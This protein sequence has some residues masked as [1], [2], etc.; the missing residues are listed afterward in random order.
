M[1]RKAQGPEL[2]ERAES[3]I[4][5]ARKAGADGAWASAST[6]RSTQYQVRDGELERMQHSHSRRLSVQ[7]YVEGRYFSHS[8]SDLRDVQLREFMTEAVALTRALQPDPHRRLPDPKLFEGQSTLD[9]QAVDESLASFGEE[10]RKVLSMVMDSRMAGKEGVIS[11][12]STVVDG[13]Y[14]SAQASSN[15]FAGSHEATFVATYANVTLQGEGD[16][17]P[18][19]G[20]GA[21][22]RHQTDLLDATWIGEEALRRARS[23]LGSTKGPTTTTT[24]VVDRQSAGRLVGALLRPASGRAVQQGQSFWAD[25]LGVPKISKALTLTDEPLLPR[26]M[27]SR[28]FDGEGIASHPHTL[29]EGGALQTMFIDTYYGRKLGVAPTLS[30][31]SNLVVKPG[32]GDLD[33]L[34]ADAGTGIYVTSW[35]GGN[36]D[37]TSGEFSL[38]LRGHLI[39]GGKIGA[40]VGE[41]NVTGKLTELFSKLRKVG[42]DPWTYGTFHSP[43]LVFEDVTFS[44]A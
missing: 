12:S 20:M 25:Q 1:A 34:V 3:A 15:G 27:G 36:S 41:M 14:G 18:E 13:R 37:A 43:T 2:L 5:L 42:A 22:A 21:S 9:L 40:P 31:P 33:S 24:M 7:L 44:G 35:L 26:A 30:S 10:D 17:R 8:T 19:G 23:R 6:S 29:I 4:E 16:R 32:A 39:E 11:A 38:G 28:H